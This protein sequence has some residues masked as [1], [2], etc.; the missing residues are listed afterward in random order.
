MPKQN[1]T[2][3]NRPANDGEP[4]ELAEARASYRAL[5]DGFRSIHLATVGGDGRPEASYAPAIADESAR[6]YVY[7]SELAAH[8]PNLRETA[9]ASALI[10]EDEATCGTIF[11]RKRVT[12][13]CEA[14]EI[15]RRS[16]GWEGVIERFEAT[17]G[18]TMSHLKTMADFHLFRL[19]PR[20]GRLV[21][22]FGK[23]YDVGGARME[24]LGHVGAG[25][26]GGHRRDADGGKG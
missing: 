4:A 17:F 21:L 8:T 6:L 25:A 13:A 26:G 20:S 11:A 10:I 1:T 22:G 5:L 18:K 9:R 24:E 16:D 15:E 3:E 12:F 7:V 2:P 23:A 14:E 19:R